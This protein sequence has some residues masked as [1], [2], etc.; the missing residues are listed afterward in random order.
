MERLRSHFGTHFSIKIFSSGSACRSYY[1]ETVQAI[2]SE[3]SQT[4]LHAIETIT[5]LFTNFAK[6]GLVGNTTFKFE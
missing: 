4:N 3:H 6:Y 2:D 1:D 5:K